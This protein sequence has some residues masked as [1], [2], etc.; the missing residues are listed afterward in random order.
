MHVDFFPFPVDKS[1]HQPTPTHLQNKAHVFT[2]ALHIEVTPGRLAP[3]SCFR[4]YT[5][6]SCCYCA[7][8]LIIKHQDLSANRFMI[9]YLQNLE[10]YWN[11][12]FCGWSLMLCNL[13]WRFVGS[14]MADKVCSAA[15]CSNMLFL[16]GST[17]SWPHIFT[18]SGRL[19]TLWYRHTCPALWLSSYHRSPSGLTESLSLPELFLV[20]FWHAAFW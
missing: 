5:L 19:G 6:V 9:V 1:A 10:I 7:I 17:S 4:K 13:D 15:F 2:K 16:Q 14:Y 11:H 3:I 18:S 8:F 12:A 20:S